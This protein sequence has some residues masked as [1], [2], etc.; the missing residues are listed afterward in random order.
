MKLSK[1]PVEGLPVQE[2]L[3][4]DFLFHNYI[5]IVEKAVVKFSHEHHIDVTNVGVG[6][7]YVTDSY[8]VLIIIH[9]IL[10]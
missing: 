10:I 4:R 5:N 6:V 3:V 7:L 8:K 1:L 9:S 2:L